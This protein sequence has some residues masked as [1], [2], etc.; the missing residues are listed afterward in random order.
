MKNDPKRENPV[1]NALR[2]NEILSIFGELNRSAFFI[3][4]LR[5]GIRRREV[6]RGSTSGKGERL[7]I[8]RELR[9]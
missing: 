1:G 7:N 8:R 6:I 2:M 9:K 5:R 3:A 4:K